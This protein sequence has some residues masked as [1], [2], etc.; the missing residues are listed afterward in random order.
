MNGPDLILLDEPTSA[1]DKKNEKKI[2][3]FLNSIK[4]NKIII[5]VS[6]KE[7]QKKYFDEII[8]L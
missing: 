8:N 7:D 5:V 2:L 3:A 4:K 6:H 1:L